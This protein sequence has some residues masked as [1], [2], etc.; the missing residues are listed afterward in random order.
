MSVTILQTIAL[1]STVNAWGFG[2]STSKVQYLMSNGDVWVSGK[3]H[4]RHQPS[5]KYIQCKFGADE[6][7]RGGLHADLD[8]DLR[9]RPEAYISKYYAKREA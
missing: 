3:V 4:Y 6:S 5:V 8:H 1:P 9:G 2:G 7:F